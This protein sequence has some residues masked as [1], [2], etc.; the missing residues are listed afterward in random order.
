[1]VSCRTVRSLPLQL[2]LTCAAAPSEF[3]ALPYSSV[4]R[5][6]KLETMFESYKFMPLRLR[7]YDNSSTYSR[8]ARQI[9]VQPTDPMGSVRHV[10]VKE[11]SLAAPACANG[12]LVIV[13]FDDRSPVLT[14]VNRLRRFAGRFAVDHAQSLPQGSRRRHFKLRYC[15]SA[16]ASQSGRRCSSHARQCDKCSVQ[17]TLWLRHDDSRPVAVPRALPCAAQARS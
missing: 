17:P 10:I 15:H 16:P 3:S 1:M 12:E 13:T 4:A 7:F 9:S 5:K 8:P 6:K 14:V 2:M 11:A